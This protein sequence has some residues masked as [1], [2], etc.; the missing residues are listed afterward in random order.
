MAPC[1]GLKPRAGIL[2]AA[3]L[4]IA[5]NAPHPNAAKL[6]IKFALSEEGFVPWSAIGTYP[7]VVGIPIPEN[8][9][10]LEDVELWPSDDA[11]AYANMSQVRDFWLANYLGE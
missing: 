5:N 11:F 10:A 1:Y 9:P 2:K 8:M 4:G 6:F 3:Y 7:P